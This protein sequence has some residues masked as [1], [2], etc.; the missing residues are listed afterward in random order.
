MNARCAISNRENAYLF[1]S[2]HLN[3]G[4]GTDYETLVYSPNKAG[5]VIHAEIAEVLVK[6]RGIKIRP[7]VRV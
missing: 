4:G 3:A 7:D 6:D 2:I 5:N 1:V